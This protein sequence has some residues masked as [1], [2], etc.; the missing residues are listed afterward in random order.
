MK[1]PQAFPTMTCLN[2]LI[3]QPFIEKIA[4]NILVMHLTTVSYV[5]LLTIWYY[6]PWA[7]HYIAILHTMMCYVIHALYPVTRQTPT[8]RR[9]V[10]MLET[11]LLLIAPML[12]QHMV[13]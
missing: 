12:M 3:R 7:N 2:L 1:L 11:V 5:S 13:Q 10:A 9:I 8:V 4:F 6:Q